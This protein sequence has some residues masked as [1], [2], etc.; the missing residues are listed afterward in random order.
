MSRP[1]TKEIFVHR[2]GLTGD[3]PIPI[4]VI[5][6]C[7]P[8]EDGDQ[9]VEPAMDEEAAKIDQALRESLPR[10]TTERLAGLLLKRLSGSFLGPMEDRKE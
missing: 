6:I 2:A 10:G 4:Q 3:I 8:W 9:T 5:H 7:T 1:E